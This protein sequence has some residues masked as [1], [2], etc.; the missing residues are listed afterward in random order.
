M[1]WSSQIAQLG[2]VVVWT[3]GA[4]GMKGPPRHFEALGWGNLWLDELLSWW[5]GLSMTVPSFPHMWHHT[6][7]LYTLPEPPRRKKKKKKQPRGHRS[8]LTSLE[9]VELQVVPVAH[10]VS[11]LQSKHNLHKVLTMEITATPISWDTRGQH[12]FFIY[13]YNWW[14]LVLRWLDTLI[15]VSVL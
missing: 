1:K 2:A 15:F 12:V 7:H 11:A 3:L 5:E 8:Y 10:Q 6:R 13:I 9:R 4:D 14:V